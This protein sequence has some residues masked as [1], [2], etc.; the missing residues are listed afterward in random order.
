[1]KTLIKSLIAFVSLIFLTS[2]TTTID[3]DKERKQITREDENGVIKTYYKG[4]PFSGVIERYYGDSEQLRYSLEYEDGVEDGE[5]KEFFKN[6]Q[7]YN[8]GNYKDGKKDGLFEVYDSTGNL[9]DKGYYKDG[10][11]IEE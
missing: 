8:I 7:L 5:Y 11:L 10:D 2:C 9:K 6:G 4:E 3:Y 1:M